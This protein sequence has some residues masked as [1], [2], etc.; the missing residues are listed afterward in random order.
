MICRKDRGVPV[1]LLPSGAAV[2]GVYAFSPEE[3]RRS[4]DRVNDEYEYRALLRAAAFV[5]VGQRGP[6]PGVSRFSNAV[7][8]QLADSG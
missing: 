1:L 4:A 5:L 7:Y 8:A 3:L 6:G 2:H